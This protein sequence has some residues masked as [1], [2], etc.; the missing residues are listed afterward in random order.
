MTSN[1][2]SCQYYNELGVQIQLVM[3]DVWNLRDV[4]ARSHNVRRVLRDFLLYRERSL[5]AVPHDLAHLIT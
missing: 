4:V 5:M 3:V 2:L 1:Y